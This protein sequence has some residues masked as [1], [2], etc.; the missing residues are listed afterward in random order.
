MCAAGM[1]N[2]HL[3]SSLLSLSRVY[4]LAMFQELLDI[5]SKEKQHPKIKHYMDAITGLAKNWPDCETIYISKV[6]LRSKGREPPMLM[7]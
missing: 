6:H 3:P 1:D 7:E 4:S 5:I 2:P